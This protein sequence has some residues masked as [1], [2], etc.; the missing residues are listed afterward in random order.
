MVPFSR[1]EAVKP[2]CDTPV[3]SPPENKS[4]NL[5]EPLHNRQNPDVSLKFEEKGAR[6]LNSGLIGTKISGPKRFMIFSRGEER[7]IGVHVA[8][9]Q[10]QL[11]LLAV[12]P[13]GTHLCRGI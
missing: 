9:N 12:T 7:G 10:M 3:A 1:L 6:Q 11:L 4:K 8:Q 2:G 13:P 5:Q